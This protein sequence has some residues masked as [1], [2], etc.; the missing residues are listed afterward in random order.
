VTEGNQ[1]NTAEYGWA[2]RHRTTMQMKIKRLN[3][4]VLRV[5]TYHVAHLR[6]QCHKSKC[7]IFQKRL[8]KVMKC[9]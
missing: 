5:L 6:Q 4:L 3:V 7:V 1:K 9:C 2:R 8:L